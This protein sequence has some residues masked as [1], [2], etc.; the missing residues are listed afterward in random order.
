MNTVTVPLANFPNNKVNTERLHLEIIQNDLIVSALDGIF[1]EGDT[2]DIVFKRDLDAPEIVALDV[3]IAAHTGEAL[4]AVSQSVTIAG[5]KS[6][7]DNKLVV[8]VW[9]T[10]GSRTNLISHNWCDPTTWFTSSVRISED[11]EPQS[12]GVYQTSHPNIIDLSHGKIFGEDFLEQIEGRPLKCIVSVAGQIRAE[13]DPDLLVGDY[14]LDYRTGQLTFTVD[15]A[16]GIVNVTYNYAT[17][18]RWYL[19]PADGKL[20]RLKEVEVQFSRNCSIRDTVEFQP[21]GQAQYF[22]PQ[23][24]AAGVVGPEEYISLSNAVR[25]K[26]MKDFLDEANG[27]LP[28]TPKTSHASPSWRDLP[29]EVITFPWNYQATINLFSSKKMRI[30]VR[31]L[32]DRPYEGSFATSTFYALSEVEE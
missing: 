11:L 8:S 23:L 12:P 30:Q 6:T 24:V 26:T 4:P 21:Q 32:N 15:P 10:E 9:P 2:I 25:Y 19:E 27:S 20:L 7:P 16:P 14:T 18:S 3:V 29:D 13:M 5:L 1:V 28:P 31:L 22:A 17:D